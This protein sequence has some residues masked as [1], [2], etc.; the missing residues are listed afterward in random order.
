MDNIAVVEKVVDL[1]WR[2]SRSVY[3]IYVAVWPLQ[4]I[5]K[6]QYA[7][8]LAMTTYFCAGAGRLALD[9][10]NMHLDGRD[11]VCAAACKVAAACTSASTHTATITNAPP[12]SATRARK[13]TAS[14]GAL[15]AVCPAKKC[16]EHCTQFDRPLHC[17]W[18]L[19]S[20]ISTLN[21]F[22]GP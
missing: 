4:A 15:H 18:S 6:V 13:S 16:L 5:Q 3:D 9:L 21:K 10:Q 19:T 2:V 12:H 20:L 8:A 11:D 22:F 17:V 14:V 7:P 1:G